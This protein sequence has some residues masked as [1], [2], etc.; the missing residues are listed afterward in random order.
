ME[1]NELSMNQ[2]AEVIS[3]AV[4]A[5]LR[6]IDSIRNF[7]N[8]QPNS[9]K[10]NRFDD[11]GVIDENH[12]YG[13]LSGV[14][15]N[16]VV[17]TPDRNYTMPRRND[18][19]I[20]VDRTEQQKKM[21]L[22]NIHKGMT[23]SAEFIYD[24]LSYLPVDP[25]PI[26]AAFKGAKKVIKGIKHIPDAIDDYRYLKAIRNIHPQEVKR[27]RNQHFLKR[28]NTKLLDANGMPELQYHTVQ[29][30]YDPTFKEFNPAQ[31]Q[32]SSKA[33][34][35]TDYLPMSQ[36]YAAKPNKISREELE[37]LLQ[38]EL[39]KTKEDWKN[40]TGT[41]MPKEGEEQFL[42]NYRKILGDKNVDRTKSLY[43]RTTNPKIIDAN[44]SFWN[45]IKHLSDRDKD[46]IKRHTEDLSN[47]YK[48]NLEDVEDF[49][50][51]DDISNTNLAKDIKNGKISD[52]VQIELQA[53]REY[54]FDKATKKTRDIEKLYSNSPYDAVIID[55][56]IDYG[57]HA[58]IRDVMSKVGHRVVETYDPFNLK[59]AN[60]IT[61]DN[62]GKLIRLS[63]RDNFL[64]PDIRYNYGGYLLNDKQFLFNT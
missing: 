14:P 33:I 5:G 46:I 2:R 21:M 49:I 64:N 1:W 29:E 37:K 15:M 62:K 27:L 61:R 45:G 44:H 55:N 16:E 58:D 41:D 39:E 51:L 4:K 19:M 36:S 54:L 38:K 28:S 59:L 8:N 13:G 11:G 20:P 57:G 50:I 7:Y 25:F 17:V 43:I 56:V 47:N 31:E 60:P 12:I 35:S 9:T 22:D 3:M 52:T 48:L 26:G 53:L 40:F 63:Q 30:P 34:Y 18:S 42:K 23:N 10:S 6:D 24:A 32:S